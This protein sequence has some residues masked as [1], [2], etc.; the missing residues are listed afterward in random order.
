M[1]L[2]H[3]LDPPPTFLVLL[4][5]RLPAYFLKHAVGASRPEDALVRVVR[6]SPGW[7]HARNTACVFCIALGVGDFAVPGVRV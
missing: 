4:R 6:R 3:P 7:P 5:H 2:P 1:N